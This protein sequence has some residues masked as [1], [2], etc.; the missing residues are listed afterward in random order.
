MLQVNVIRDQ[1]DKVIKSLV[2]RNW[3][4]EKTAILDQIIKLDDQ[5]KAVQ[6]ENDNQL[7]IVNTSSKE[8]GMLMRDGKKDEAEALKSKVSLLKDTIKQ[9]EENLR[10]IKKKLL[11]CYFKCLI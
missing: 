9:A 3:P 6:T 7:N 8:I 5:R 1:K 10:N 4:L 2:K 11:T